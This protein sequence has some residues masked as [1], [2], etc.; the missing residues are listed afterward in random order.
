MIRVNGA[1]TEW[2]DADRQLAGHPGCLGVMLPKA[3]AT[4][5]VDLIAADAPVVPLIETA[6]GV[7]AM[8]EVSRAAGVARLALGTVDLALDLDLPK[9]GPVFDT[10]RLQMTIASRA[11]GI[12]APIDGV[13]TAFRDDTAATAAMWAARTLGFAAKLCIH[14]RQI[15]AVEA[16][17]RP[18]PDELQRARRIV[19]AD[20]AAGGGA[21]SVDGVMVDRP[22]AERARRLLAGIDPPS[23][24]TV[25]RD[26]GG[27]GYDMRTIE[28]GNAR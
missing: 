26:I 18:G 3:A 5:V 14:P 12:A 28:E 9:D 13:T 17:L 15:G 21:A 6:T 25:V 4:D 10:I 16:A 27:R 2:F 22:V 23:A 11:A 19:A 20:D 7:L 8:S 1:D 24:T